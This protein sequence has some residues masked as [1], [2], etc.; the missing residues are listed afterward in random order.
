MPKV[1]L[2]MRASRQ[3]DDDRML[4]ALIDKNLKIRGMQKKELAVKTG[5]AESTLYSRCRKPG[6]FKRSELRRIFNVLGFSDEDKA[7]IKW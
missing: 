4:I 6:D 2:G 3:T 1:K 7:A 5:M